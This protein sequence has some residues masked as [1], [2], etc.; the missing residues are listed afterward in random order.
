[1][2]MEYRDALKDFTGQGAILQHNQALE[3]TH[4]Y[5]KEYGNYD[6][7]ASRVQELL[8]TVQ[9]TPGEQEELGE[10]INRIAA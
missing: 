9:L 6:Q 1:M 7:I 8:S 3:H 2:Q 5:L 10:Y 4:R